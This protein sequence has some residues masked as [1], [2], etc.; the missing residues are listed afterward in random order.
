VAEEPSGGGHERARQ[1]HDELD[2]LDLDAETVA[3]LEPDDE[4]GDQVRGGAI[5]AGT[6]SCTA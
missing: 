3:D 2:D 1:R 6:A 5:C 4:E